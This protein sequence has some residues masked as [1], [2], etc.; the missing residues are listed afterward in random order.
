MHASSN[1]RIA[2]VVMAGALLACAQGLVQAQQKYPAKPIRLVVAF[3]A[4]SATDITSRLIAARISDAWGQPIIIENR[5][6]ASGTLA[7]TVVAKATPDGYTLLATSGAFA[8]AAALRREDP[9]R[10]E[11]RRLDAAVAYFTR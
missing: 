2:S 11:R 5:A 4:G 10:P 7:A 3:T 6:G 8:I 9:E 1:F